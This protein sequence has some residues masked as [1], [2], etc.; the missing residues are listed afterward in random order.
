MIAEV[1]SIYKRLYG[2][3]LEKNACFISEKHE[4][5]RSYLRPYHQRKPLFMAFLY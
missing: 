3:F 4:P 2:L 5:G 1:E